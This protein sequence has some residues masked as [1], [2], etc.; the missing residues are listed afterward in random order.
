MILFTLLMWWDLWT[1]GKR[2]QTDV[3]DDISP[4]T[5]STPY[6]HGS[7]AGKVLISS[8]N[9]IRPRGKGVFSLIG[10]IVLSVICS[11]IL[12]GWLAVIW[13]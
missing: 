1:F 9:W 11:L 8:E 13:L 6:P 3:G 12:L 7:L 2:L 4:A 10:K 5:E